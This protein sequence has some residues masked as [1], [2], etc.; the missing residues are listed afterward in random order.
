VSHLAYDTIHCAV[1]KDL[2]NLRLDPKVVRRIDEAVKR[3][4][5]PNRSEALRQIVLRFMEEHPE[6]FRPP[7]IDWLL[8]GG[9]MSDQEFERLA[10]V[11]FGG[12]DAAELVAEGRD[13]F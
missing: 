7:S 5:F 3:G 2:V 9:R 11:A 10:S 6:L 4:I 12:T 8:K 1:A 13:R